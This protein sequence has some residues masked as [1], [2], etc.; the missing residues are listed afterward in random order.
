MVVY[1]INMEEINTDK[2]KIIILNDPGIIITDGITFLETIFSLDSEPDTL[3]I[4]KDNL[5]GAFFDLKTGVAGDILQKISNYRKRLIILGDFTDL[6]S[7]SLND[8][9]YE[10]NNNGQ[11]IFADEIDKAV[12]MLR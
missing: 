4:A 9:I 2:G 8:F 6:K 10:S 5:T 1:N 7:K 11:V 3:V 12:R